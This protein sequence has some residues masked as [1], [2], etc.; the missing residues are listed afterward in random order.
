MSTGTVRE[1]TKIRT[2]FLRAIEEDEYEKAPSGMFLRS[3][4]KAYAQSIGLDADS[5]ANRYLKAM[6]D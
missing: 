6:N 3:Y 5:V 2:I 4:V 1:M